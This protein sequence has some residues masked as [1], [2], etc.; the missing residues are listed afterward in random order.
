VHLCQHLSVVTKLVNCRTPFLNAI[1]LLSVRA[2]CSSSR[3]TSTIAASS[4]C[5]HSFGDWL[6]YDNEHKGTLHWLLIAWRID[7]TL[8]LLVRLPFKHVSRSA[9][10]LAS[11]TVPLVRNRFPAYFKTLHSH[12]VFKRGSKTVFSPYYL[13]YYR[14]LLRVVYFCLFLV[15]GKTMRRHSVCRRSMKWADVILSL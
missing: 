7:Y 9:R 6:S 12:S 1:R 13:Q 11:S 10:G 5:R 15:F 2:C 3:N 8:Y 14:I 4:S